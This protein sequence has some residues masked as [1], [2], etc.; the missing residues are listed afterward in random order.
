MMRCLILG[1]ICVSISGCAKY[2]APSTPEEAEAQESK[3]R[4]WLDETSPRNSSNVPK[5]TPEFKT[6][7]GRPSSSNSTS[8]SE[9]VPATKQSEDDSERW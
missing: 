1:L 3:S 2:A 7:Y 4:Y 8:D 9:D 6:S 5:V